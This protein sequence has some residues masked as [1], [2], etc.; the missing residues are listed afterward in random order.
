MHLRSAASAH[1]TATTSIRQHTQ[2]YVSIRPTD[3]PEK[4]CERARHSHHR[5]HPHHHTL[6]AHFRQHHVARPAA[7]V[8]EIYQIQRI[9]LLLLLLLPP[10]RRRRRILLPLPPLTSTPELRAS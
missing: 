2:A 3:A 8:R 4:N 1:A 6:A 9:R 10:P 7:Q 5:H